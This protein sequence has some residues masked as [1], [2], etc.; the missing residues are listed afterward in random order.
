MG[1][2]SSTPG[3]EQPVEFNQ[4]MMIA[5]IGRMFSSDSATQVTENIPQ[6]DIHN[7]SSTSP[8]DVSTVRPAEM[9]GGGRLNY[10]RNRYQKFEERLGISNA[11]RDIADGLVQ[12]GG[13]GDGNVAAGQAPQASQTL[14][15]AVPVPDAPKPAADGDDAGTDAETDAGTDE[16]APGDSSLE[17]DVDAL[18]REAAA[19]AVEEDHGNPLT[20]M[21]G[22]TADMEIENIRSLLLNTGAQTGGDCGGE[23]GEQ[24]MD[25]NLRAVRDN[26]LNQN[27]SATSDID[28]PML[29]GGNF[30]TTSENPIDYN[31]IMQG[32]AKKDKK[33]KD[34]STSESSLTDSSSDSSRDTSSSDSS[35]DSSMSSGDEITATDIMLIQGGID[36]NRNKSNFLKGDYVL[37]SNSD[38]NYKMDGRPFFSSQSSEFSN[39]VAS[40]FLNTLRSRNRS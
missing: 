39:E 24:K 26:L 16:K 36:K 22:M 37:T 3:R 32:G 29:G 21:G 38:H 23:H 14:E 6:T 17:K 40:E 35:S 2:G 34:D 15:D 28:I 10:S 33:S 8:V 31:L 27:Y 30:S 9:V 20:Q 11:N 19:A 18:L 12:L 13:D 4:D 25:M 5:D 7:F 1:Q